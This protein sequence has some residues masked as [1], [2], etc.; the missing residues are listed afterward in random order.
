M[1]S[2]LVRNTAAFP[3]RTAVSIYVRWSDGSL[4]RGSGTMVG[5]NDVLTAAHV[6]YDPNKTAVS[7]GVAPGQA[8]RNT[9]FSIVNAAVWNYYRI[10]FTS[11]GNL[12]PRASG[13]DLAVIGLDNPIGRTTGWLGVRSNASG[14]FSR[15]LIHY[16]SHRAISFDDL[17]QTYSF[18]NVGTDPTRNYLNIAGLG[19]SSGS[20]GGGIYQILRRNGRTSRFVNGVVSTASWGAYINTS[21]FR[22]IRTWMNRNNRYLDSS[23]T[24][25]RNLGNAA[26]ARTVGGSVNSTNQNQ[27]RFSFHLNANRTTS[28]TLSNLSSDADIY[29]YDAS[30]RFITSSQNIGT[31]NDNITTFLNRGIYYVDVRQFA[32]SGGNTYNLSVG[33]FGAPGT[34][35]T[36]RQSPATLTSSPSGLRSP[37]QLLSASRPAQLGGVSLAGSQW[38]STIRSARLALS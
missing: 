32:A 31:S 13:S 6:I 19:I 36:R 12:T 14:T 3:Y 4:S 2:R 29:L 34:S 17:R 18:A 9:R 8:R 33:P 21:R 5:V 1:P 38:Q 24:H 26:T 16:P 22:A 15:N 28:I 23:R 7:I 20:S 10:P 11:N 25:Y 30:G 27:D 35:L 37:N